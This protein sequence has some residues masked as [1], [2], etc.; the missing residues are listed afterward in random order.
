[1]LQPINTLVLRD[2]VNDFLSRWH[3]SFIIDYWWRK[4]HNVAF[5]SPEHRQMNFIDMFVEYCEDEKIKQIQEREQQVD[6]DGGIRMS[7]KEIDDDYDKLDLT[8][9]GNA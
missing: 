1:M 5:G 8:G 3:S 7:Q 6:D 2:D 4:K 9:F